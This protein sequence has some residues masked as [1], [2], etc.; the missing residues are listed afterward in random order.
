[1]QMPPSFC[2]EGRPLSVVDAAAQGN[3]VE[4]QDQATDATTNGMSVHDVG[5]HGRCLA[6]RSVFGLGRSRVSGHGGSRYRRF[7]RTWDVGQVASSGDLD[8]VDM[9]LFDT[10][11]PWL[12]HPKFVKIMLE[13]SGLCVIAQLVARDE[14]GKPAF[15]SKDVTERLLGMTNNTVLT[16]R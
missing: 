13:E 11:I 9:E 14:Q 1:M 10:L 3:S 7:W 12:K 15:P 5:C 16:V 8:K 6:N 2:S 4:A